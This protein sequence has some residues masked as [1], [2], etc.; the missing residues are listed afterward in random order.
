VASVKLDGHSPGALLVQ[1]TP[2]MRG[3]A[4]TFLAFVT[5]L[6]P[7]L[8]L[9]VAV[10]SGFLPKAIRAQAP[11]V[12][13][14]RLPVYRS[15][16][17]SSTAGAMKLLAM[18]AGPG[19]L[20]IHANGLS[21]LNLAAP[22][23]LRRAAPVFVHFHASELTARSRR[24][25]RLWRTLGV[26]MEFFPVSDFNKGLLEESEVRDLVRA[27]LPNPMDT[28]VQAADR[29]QPHRPFRV[30]FVGS[31]SPNKGLHL[32]VA[33]AGLLRND[34]VEWHI[35]GIDLRPTAPPYVARCLRS[36]RHS[37]LE[38]R[39]RWWGKQEDMKRAYAD[40]DA[41]L[42]PSGLESQSRVAVE[43]MANG[44]PVVATR[45]GGLPE[46]V[47]DGI[48]GWLFD[49][50][51]ADEAA[52]HLRRI[53]DDA[54]LWSQ[55]SRGAIEAAARFD[56]ATVGRDLER[57]YEQMLAEDPGGGAPHLLTNEMSIVSTALTDAM[58]HER[59][60]TKRVGYV[61]V[62]GPDGSGKTAVIDQL[63][64][65]AEAEAVRV[66]LVFWRPKL[67]PGGLS[68]GHPVK[69][70]EAALAGR[71]RGSTLR[72]LLTLSDYLF[73][74]AISWRRSRSEG[75]LF[76]QRGWYDMV[77]DPNRYGLSP[78]LARFAS[79][80]GRLAPRPDVVVV[81]QGDAHAIATRKPELS[82]K[83]IARQV[84]VWA[85]LAP[86]A[87]RRALHLDSV[88]NSPDQIAKVVWDSLPRVP[89]DAA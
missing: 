79:L 16:T 60:S 82:P 32:L 9:T 1:A 78:R 39:F 13:I 11:T 48:S 53:V 75:L 69:R 30:G 58:E 10:P 55:L 49:P 61:L 64:A 6:A 34:D 26:R 27:T 20:L 14:V 40:V 50:V 23:A 15:R 21:A 41:L 29:E 8:P 51:H 80:L 74:Q 45:V 89:S 37:G 67:I 2:G 62:V 42:V 18:R 68:Y 36:I 76:V 56:I 22:L 54:E 4:R 86:R 63:H 52:S 70:G 33:I 71:G 84:E 31:K 19:R 28:S 12:R 35:F 46:V 7:R 66:A 44:L 38:D 17:V 47:I 83:E 87:G 85:R 65:M 5:Y 3:P 73:A 43:A 24:F 72:L 57:F 88:T 59:E 77:V 81:L 25:L